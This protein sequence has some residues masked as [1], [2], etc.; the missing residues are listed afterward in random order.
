MIFHFPGDGKMTKME[1]Q[2]KMDTTEGS[3]SKT[4]N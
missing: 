4:E 3:V 2:E 1:V